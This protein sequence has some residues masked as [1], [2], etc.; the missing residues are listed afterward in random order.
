VRNGPEIAIHVRFRPTCWRPTEHGDESVKE[1]AG[2]LRRGRPDRRK[3]PGST[4]LGRPPKAPEGPMTTEAPARCR[5]RRRGAFIFAVGHLVSRGPKVQPGFFLHRQR[6]SRRRGD[7]GGDVS[8]RPAPRSAH[9]N[10]RRG[11]LLV[12]RCS[13][14]RRRVP[15]PWSAVACDLTGASNRLPVG[16][17]TG[18]R[19]RVFQDDASSVTPE[20]QDR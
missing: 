9:Q 3:S 6:R 19:A 17:A 4:G 10:S 14:L 1:G 8:R 7:L 5:R 20:G 18:R 2:G 16:H 11:P 12:S 15:R 13:S